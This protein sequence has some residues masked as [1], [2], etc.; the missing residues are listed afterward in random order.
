MGKVIVIAEA[1]VNHN[2]NI[3][4]AFQLIDVAVTAKA[5]YVKFQTWKSEN[6][7]SKFAVKAEYQKET[8]SK[9][10][11]MLEMLKKL[12]LQYEQFSQLNNYCG[13]RGIGFLS[14]P[15]D[16]ES[17]CFLNEMGMEYFK[18]PSGEITNLPLLELI[19]SFKKK[20][21]LS[22]GM[23]DIEEIFEAVNVLRTNG[24]G[25]ISLLQCNTE[26]PTPYSDVNLAAMKTLRDYFDCE[27]GYSD[28]SIGIEVPIAAVALGA[29]IIE[30]HFTLDKAMIG[31]DHAASLEPKELKQ[32]VESIRHIEMAIGCENKLVTN[33]EKKN[34]VAVR[35]SIVAACKI[36]K[37]EPLTINNIAVKRPGNGISPM[38]WYEV[39]GKQA[40]RDFFEDEPIE[41]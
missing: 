22:T 39:L 16:L 10:E 23:S 5:D 2:G 25:I 35:K 36:V 9:N 24:S 19:G 29:T 38:S 17:A 14:T 1:G 18:V 4:L 15:F 8:T 41:C 28:H 11:S 30:K 27:V 37:G 3:A 40:V 32:M 21:I 7:I 31:P 34:L 33:S 12:E 20:V 13:E 26:Y 6:I